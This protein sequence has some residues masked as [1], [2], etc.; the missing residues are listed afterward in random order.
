MLDEQKMALV[1]L[2]L[3]ICT[4]TTTAERARPLLQC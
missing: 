3:D 4:Q 1:N 2:L